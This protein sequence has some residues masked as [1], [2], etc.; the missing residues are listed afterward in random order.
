MKKTVSV[1][2]SVLSVS[3]IAL[4]GI[5]PG[6]SVAKP[7]LGPAVSQAEFVTGNTAF[8]ANLYAKL[9]KRDGNI[10]FSPYSISTALAMTYAGARGNTATQM[11]A[12]LH[13]SLGQDALH[14]AFAGQE[15]H[16][17]DIQSKKK[18][19]LHVA[20]SLW[21]QKDYPF[22]PTY[23]D[24][25]KRN[26]GVGITPVDFKG[27]AE[28]ART[29]INRWV[30]GKTNAR[31]KDLMPVGVLDGWTR[32]VLVNAIYFKGNWAQQFRKW[33][34]RDLPSLKEQDCYCAYNDPKEM[35]RVRRGTDIPS[36]GHALCRQ[37]SVNDC[38]PAQGRGWT[39]R[40]GEGPL[41]RDSGQMDCRIAGD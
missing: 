2:L 35:V 4:A 33:A 29:A 25:V 9:S 20:N 24:L 28:G 15:R 5:P 13:F 17:N 19:Q 30:E 40:D 27:N 6:P 11:A 38:C 26:Y 31:I 8:A 16:L 12:T 36:V 14:V 22:L 39:C 18:V 10:F 37:R 23:L 41:G 34:T 32:L 21:P 7:P 1:C 3:A